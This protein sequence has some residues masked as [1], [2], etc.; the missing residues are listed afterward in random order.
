MIGGG[1]TRVSGEGDCGG[2]A[3]GCHFFFFFF[4]K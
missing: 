2:R 3:A 1:E 4:V